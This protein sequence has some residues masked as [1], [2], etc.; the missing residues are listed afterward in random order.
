MAVGSLT[1]GE[2]ERKGT[3]QQE[4]L[5]RPCPLSTTGQ[6]A[7][8]P[9][10]PELAGV[11]SW[12]S[13]AGWPQGLPRGIS[14]PLHCPKAQQCVCKSLREHGPP[15]T[16]WLAARAG[17][18]APA[19]ARRGGRKAPLIPQEKPPWQAE[20]SECLPSAPARDHGHRTPGYSRRALRLSALLT[21]VGAVIPAELA[22]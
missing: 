3:N 12:F 13:P 19:P 11:Q 14:L 1:S 4:T 5:P 15:N 8:F 20:Q 16:G 21:G 17:V 9:Q 6:A 7:L 10:K 2:R 18:L 22:G